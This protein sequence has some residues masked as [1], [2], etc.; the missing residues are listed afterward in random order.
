[1]RKSLSADSYR[2]I[3]DGD[4]SFE[5]LYVFPRAYEQV[6]FLVQALLPDRE[7]D[8]SGRIEHAFSAFPWRGG[9]SAVNFYNQL[10]YATPPDERPQIVSM[11][12]G[13]PGWFD[14][15]LVIAAAISVERIVRSV[16]SSI[17]HAHG[18]YDRVVKGMIDRKLLRLDAKRKELQFRQEELTYIASSVSQIARLLGLRNVREI[19][20][21]TGHPY[22][23]LKILLSLYR[24]VKKLVDYINKGKVSIG[25]DDK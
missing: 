4:W 17:D 8:S 25:D 7:S 14:L 6:Y 18:V 12:K 9:Y 2:I 16:A 5:D 10:K 15:A 13:S 19:N 24:R 20:Q 3:I 23:T 1:M 22:I 21:L 11:H